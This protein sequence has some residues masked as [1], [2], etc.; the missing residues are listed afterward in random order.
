MYSSKSGRDEY[1]LKWDGSYGVDDGLSSDP[2]YVELSG[3]F[4]DRNKSNYI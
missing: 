3:D 4:H 1:D 2:K